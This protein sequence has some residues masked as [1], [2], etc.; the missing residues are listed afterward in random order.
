MFRVLTA[1]AAGAAAMFLLDPAG[2]RRRRALVRDKLVRAAHVARRIA[3]GKGE[4]LVDRSRGF[5]AELRSAVRRDALDDEQLEARVR[6][7][8]GHVASHP[9]ALEARVHHGVVTVAGIVPSDEVA[10][11]LSAIGGVRGVVRVESLLET[12]DPGR[13]A[14]RRLA[15]SGVRGGPGGET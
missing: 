9:H 15:S 3:A 13:V 11:V 5:V 2:G 12:G 8:L 7:R 1:L 10:P 4:H 14:R 6:A